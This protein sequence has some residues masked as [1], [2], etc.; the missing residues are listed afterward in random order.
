MI[1][2]LLLPIAIVFGLGSPVQAQDEE[3][4]KFTAFVENSLS[5]AGRTVTISGFRGALS[6]RAEM[7]EM[8]IADD[9]GV[10]ITL[11]D[12][13]LDWNRLGLLRGRFNINELTASEIILERTPV[14]AESDVPAAEAGGFALPELPVSVRVG[15]LAVEH[16]SLGPTILGEP[17][18]AQLEASAE[19]ADGEGEVSLNLQRTDPGKDGSVSLD[20]AYANET[21]QTRI[22]LLAD[23][24]TEGI[25]AR[26]LGLPGQPAIRLEV[27]GEGL[28]SDLT[29]DVS[30]QTDGEPRLQ[31]SVTL[32]RQE[33]QAMGFGLDLT[34][35]MAPLF[36][37]QYQDFF[38]PE[39]VLRVDGER[40]AEGGISLSA[41]DISSRA[42]VLNGSADIAQD[43]LPE[44]IS[45]QGRVAQPDGR[46]LLLP[47]GGPVETR[48]TSADL[49]F[50]FDATQGDGWSGNVTVTGLDR[51][52]IALDDV[53]LQGT[54]RISR[55]GGASV[56]GDL[57]FAAN[58]IRPA[59][60]ALATAIGSDVTGATRFGWDRGGTGLEIES[61]SLNG[62]D[63]GLSA[64]GRFGELAGGFPFAG[65]M[66]ARHDDLTRL[67]PI[68]KRPLAGMAQIEAE[69]SGSLLGGDFDGELRARTTNL[70]TGI[71]EV[72]RLLTGQA[73]MDL[74]ARRDETGTILRRFDLLA[75]QLTASAT[76]RLSSSGND[77]E[78]DF[79]FS[80][81]SVLGPGYDGALRATAQFDGTLQDGQLRLDGVGRDLRSPIPETRGLLAGETTLTVDVAFR[82]GRYEI[83]TAEIGNDQVT[84]DVNGFYDPAGSDLAA[85]LGLPDLAV[86]GSKYH[87]ALQADLAA[88]GTLETGRLEA[89][90]Q[91][92]NLAIGQEYADRLLAGTSDLRAELNLQ[93][94]KIQIE[95]VTLDN[96]QLRANA[97][98]S[99]AD[100]L[101]QV[102]LEGQ[103]NN[104]ALI[105]PEFPGPVTVNGSLTED[106]SGFALDFAGRGPGGID[107]RMNGRIAPDFSTAD[108]SVNGI[109]QAA[110]ANPFLGSRS[111]SGRTRYD[112]RINGPLA[113]S[114][115]SGEAQLSGGRFSD[116]ALPV[117]LENI[118]VLAQLGGNTAR[119]EGSLS[120]TTGGRIRVNGPIGLTSPFRA[121]LGIA[122]QAV[123]LRDPE[124][125]QTTLNG[126][127]Q[128]AGP[129]TGGAMISGQIDVGETELR[130]PSTGFGGGADLP[131]LRHINEPGNVHS[132]RRRAGLLTEELNTARQS[133][134]AFGLDVVISAPSRIFI[135]GRGLDAELGGR[136]RLTGSTA[137]I[138][139]IGRFDLIRGRF[140]I[141]GKRLD[142][143]EAQLA[144]QG[145][146]IPYIRVIASNE[147]DGITSSIVVDGPATEPD[148]TFSSSPPLPEEEVLSHLLFGR[149]L[150]KISAFQAAQLAS[151]VARLAGRGGEG[152][153]SKLR[154]GFGL[155]DLDLQTDA[156][157][158]TS[159]R[160]GKY[161]SE[162]LYTEV[163][164]GIQGRSKINL[165][166]DVKPGVTVR[167]SVGGDG[168]TGIGIFVE[169]DY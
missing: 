60:T 68:A 11:K 141:L 61:L 47:L 40:A 111:I 50:S 168:Q 78:G 21:G 76:G 126:N 95:T 108:L 153:V 31:G 37:P 101:R 166:L 156:D 22:H 103:L 107:A 45:L 106:S 144:L 100:D 77:I 143:N 63:Y 96:P 20:G 73:T 75:R 62:A 5:G 87:G 109:S 94:G 151:A 69:G 113:L 132:T 146:L 133:G 161:L 81:L 159:L 79:T 130:V 30:L 163:E 15:K 85:R 33:D 24:G 23:E 125:Y 124:L 44:R 114:S 154:K 119:I 28:L 48:I 135:R 88:S 66:E 46:S 99:V 41:L 89:T 137:N 9:E 91:G 118:E 14:S 42:L 136:L 38:G 10:W 53:T 93:D 74:S 55:A 7:D 8:T 29:T 1:R 155:D 123:Q 158:N 2:K 49:R 117:A 110:L 115:L 112:L 148:I 59:D 162:N 165:N 56:T 128:V 122:L 72:D 6:S 12:L 52:D 97:T 35:D 86:L 4:N 164:V 83:A 129:L 139:P 138:I 145:D 32:T 80:D 142:L 34:G 120:P 84:A 127:L 140:D 98:G 116:P 54:G 92:R 51:A 57:T 13:V 102:T 67:T 169:K 25:V 160:A 149:G 27:Q 17:V 131:G 65:R 3:R 82:D 90:G 152:V 71:A 70:K 64:S 26:L 157:G 19:L 150:D 39:V 147:G 18:A 104:L 16:L 105:L 36:L 58:G 121:D 167:G 134:A 43:G